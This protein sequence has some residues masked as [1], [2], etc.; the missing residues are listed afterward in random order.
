MGVYFEVAMNACF[1]LLFWAY[2]REIKALKQELR[3]LKDA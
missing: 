1:V 2:G 3:F